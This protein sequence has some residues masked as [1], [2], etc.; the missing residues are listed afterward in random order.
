WEL[1]RLD[2][3]FEHMH[4]AYLRERS[5]DVSFVVRRVLQALMGRE[6]EGL[7]NVPPGVIVVA[8]DLST[9]ELAQL[10][11]GQ[12]LGI[13]TEGGSRTS[14]VTIVARSLEIRAVVGVGPGFVRGVADG[15]KLIVDGHA[16]VVISEASPP[17]VAEY[18]KRHL[19]L[20]ALERRLLRYAN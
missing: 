3:V 8:E 11:P 19:H 2:A 9:A 18:E 6:P 13:A 14:H 1:R 16:G 17:T 7:K 20:E 12:V 5:G 4:D 10:A 15:A